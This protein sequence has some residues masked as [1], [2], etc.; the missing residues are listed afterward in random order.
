MRIEFLTKWTAIMLLTATLLTGCTVEDESDCIGDMNLTFRFTREGQNNFGPQ[1]PSLSV[2]V[3]DEAGL[4]LGRWD[5]L[6]NSK[7]GSEYTMTLPLPPGTYSFVAWGGLDNS[8]YYLCAPGQN[9]SN[10]T[11]PVVGQTRIDNMLLRLFGNHSNEVAFIPI[12]QFHGEA[13]N[14]TVVAGQANDVTIDLAKNSKE[15]RLTIQGLPL[16]SSRMSAKANPFT[17][18]TMWMSAPNGGY[19]FHNIMEQNATVMTYAEQGRDSGEENSLIGSFHTLQLK[20]Q[21][22]SYTDIPYSFTL[23]DNQTGTAYHAADLLHDYISKVA[24]YNTQAKIDVEDL[25]DIVIDLSPHASVTVTVNGWKV[26]TT[27]NVIQ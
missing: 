4:F 17:Q 10:A 25:F 26:D 6:D 9:Q 8:Q 23:W 21:D 3:F 16:P 22:K 13:L 12:A 11:P 7:F 19:D 14:Q 18:L 5:E 27:G 15:I 1:V 20:L 2:F 24:A